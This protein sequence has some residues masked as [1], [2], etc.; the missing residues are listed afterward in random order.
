MKKK[1]RI[2]VIPAFL[3]ISPGE[4]GRF[5]D[6]PNATV[7]GDSALAEVIQ[8]SKYTIAKW[9]RKK[10]IP[11]KQKINYT[12]FNVLDVVNAL[13]AAG[14]SQQPADSPTGHNE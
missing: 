11:F 14:Y 2:Y 7:Y 3:K 1:K 13:R 10:T 4:Y 9:K 12:E 5:E 6:Y 8:A